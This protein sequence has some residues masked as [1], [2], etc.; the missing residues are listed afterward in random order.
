MK[1][2]L[3][4]ERFDPVRGGLEHWTWQFARQLVGRGHEVHVVA[5]DFYPAAGSD[6]IIAHRLDMPRSR[7][8]RAAALADQLPG[9]QF[10]VVH[11]MGIGWAADIIHPHG[12]STKA[13]WEHNLLR[14]PKWRQIRFWREKR[15]RELEELER[16]QHANES[17]TMVAVSR[18]VA[19]HFENLHGLPPERIRVIYNG[20]D[21]NKFTPLGREKLRDPTR[22]QLGLKDEV[23]FLM[24]AHNLLLKNAEGAIRA[25]AKLIKTGRSIHVVIAG[26]KRPERFMKLA[27]K[28][29][30]ASAVTFLDL[31]DPL[32]YYAAADVFVHP[33]WYD[34]CSLVTLEASGCGLPVITS[35]LNG[36]SEL[37]TDG[38]DGFVLS[39]PADAAT[40]AARMENLLD[41]AAR[42]K[43]GNGARVLAGKHTFAQQ[44]TQ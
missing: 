13:L 3:V 18:M 23:M 9:M 40:L 16:R 6:G 19:R 41:R 20:V 42:E 29:G 22:H 4:L 8:D 24:L 15:Y 31:V 25:A 30:I 36:M 26:G 33:T 7:L 28:L 27:Q 39:D 44:T 10:D 43:M 37:M 38:K 32:P 1:I 34:P 14:I 12:G 21:V 17:A 5:F 2:G 35:R 11:D